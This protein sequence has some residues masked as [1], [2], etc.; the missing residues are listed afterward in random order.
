MHFAH[1]DLVQLQ[2]RPVQQN[3]ESGQTGKGRVGSISGAAVRVQG[4]GETTKNRLW[5]VG[6][7]IT[8]SDNAN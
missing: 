1:A 8:V 4:T 3:E 2:Q 6:S 7:E 5:H